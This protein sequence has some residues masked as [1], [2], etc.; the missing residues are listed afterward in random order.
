LEDFNMNIG[1][2]MNSYSGFL[3]GFINFIFRYL[4]ED[5]SVM[6][7]LVAAGNTVNVG[8][9]FGQWL[10]MFFSSEVTSYQKDY[11]VYST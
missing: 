5:P 1:K 10:K 9:H 2:K 8:I 3:D 7:N 6:N 4:S 11:T